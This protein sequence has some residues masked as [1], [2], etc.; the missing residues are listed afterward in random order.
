ME[1]TIAIAVWKDRFIT[2]EKDAI[3]HTASTE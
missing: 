2:A 3:M 1:F